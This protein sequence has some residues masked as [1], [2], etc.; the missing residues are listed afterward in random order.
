MTEEHA[1][2]K[3]GK[4]VAAV[5]VLADAKLLPAVVDFVRKVADQLG[6]RG[7]AA[8]HLDRV[9]E[10][11]CRNVIDHAFGPDE[12]GRYDVYLFRQ[13]GQV[14]IAVE[15]QGLPFDYASLQDGSDTALQDMLHRSFAD[16]VNF[17]N[18]GHRGNRVELVKHLPHADVLRFVPGRAGVRPSQSVRHRL[19][20]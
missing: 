13:P 10:T 20:L 6:L 5:T 11:I 16:E 1:T 4:P 3:L 12:E 8:E 9:V 2:S 17:V 15:D 7:K 18:L 19:R 14:V